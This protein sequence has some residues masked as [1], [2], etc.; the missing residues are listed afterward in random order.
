M[1]KQKEES[2]ANLNSKIAE[3]TE[4]NAKDIELIELDNEKKFEEMKQNLQK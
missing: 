3:L 2:E 1:Q 4:E